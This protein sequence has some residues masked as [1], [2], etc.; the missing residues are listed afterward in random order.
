[1]TLFTNNYINIKIIIKIIVK[2]ICINFVIYIQYSYLHASQ[3]QGCSFTTNITFTLRR[4]RMQVWLHKTRNLIVN[5]LILQKS[6]HMAKTRA[7]KIR[8]S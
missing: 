6:E 2:G 1:M 3:T 4:I 7:P 5:F 8:Q